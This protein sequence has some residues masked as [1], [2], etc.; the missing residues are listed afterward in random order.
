MGGAELDEPIGPG[1]LPLAFAGLERPP[2][3]HV[4]R[5]DGVELARDQ[6]RQRRRRIV[7]G[8]AVDGGADQEVVLEDVLQAGLLERLLEG[9]RLELRQ[10]EDAGGGERRESTATDA[11]HQRT[12]PAAFSSTTFDITAV[13]DRVGQVRAEADADVERPVDLLRDRRP[14]LVHRLA[15]QADV[16][17][18]A[19]AAL[20]EADAPGH[21]RHQ[22]VGRVAAG[23]AAAAA[24]AELGVRDPRAPGRPLRQLDHAGPMR[25]D[26]DLRRV[27]VEI[28]ADH[29]HRLAIAVAVR[30]GVGDVG[31]QRHVAGHPLP[32]ETEFVAVVP[33]V[34][35]GGRDRVLPRR[36]VEAGAAGHDR[37]ADVRLALEDAERDLVVRAG[38]AEVRRGRHL[39]PRR[40]AWIRPVG[41]LRP[42]G[43]RLADDHGTG[44]QRERR[45]TG[46]IPRTGPA[47]AP[48]GRRWKRGHLPSPYVGLESGIYSSAK[49]SGGTA[50]GRGHQAKPTPLTGRRD[51][52]GDGRFDRVE[53]ADGE[54]GAGR[55]SAA[56]QAASETEQLGFPG[57][58]R[59]PRAR[60]AAQSA[61]AVPQPDTPPTAG[62]GAAEDAETRARPGQSGRTRCRDALH[63]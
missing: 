24:D 55:D 4:G 16:E 56:E 37:G 46:R 57:I 45:E 1:P 26:D 23:A 53:A 44:C 42:G 2:L 59:R 51:G 48:G 17:R 34:V 58:G 21:D 5:R 27:V 61:S 47:C 30:I 13:S 20:L 3:H 31:G 11:G 7:D 63:Q 52:L 10:A 54:F 8:A 6:L 12:L 36:R 22:A 60:H 19:V 25:R 35:A 18:V 33:D 29:Q 15:V 28:L 9:A 32:E 41:C 43:R 39:G 14:E 62:S 38:A 40:R 50:A 49:Q